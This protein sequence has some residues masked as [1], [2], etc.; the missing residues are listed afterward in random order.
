MEMDF[1]EMQ[2]RYRTKIL[3]VLSLVFLQLSCKNTKL[4]EET[5]NISRSMRFDAGDFLNKKG[6]LYESDTLYSGRLEYYY[7]DGSIS[8]R[9]TYWQGALEQVAIGWYPGGQN[10]WM[11][12]YEKGKKEG[13]HIRRYANGSLKSRACYK[14]DYY[15]GE[16]KEWYPNGQLFRKFN[17]VDGQESGPQKMWKSDG[18]IKANYV[19]RNGRRYGL[20]GV[21]NCVNVFEE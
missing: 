13:V 8:E 20:T 10:K 17:Y 15:E 19:V 1:L 12:Y 11:R 21:K 9:W 2:E 18:R 6:L 14:A 7:E 3:I 4:V 5:P 16:V